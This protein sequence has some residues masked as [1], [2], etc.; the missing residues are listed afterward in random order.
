M[1]GR[2]AMKRLDG[3]HSAIFDEKVVIQFGSYDALVDSLSP[4][5]LEP[6]QAIAENNPR[7]MREAAR[8]VDRDVS[9]VHSD[10]KHLEVLGILELN[11]GGPGG[12]MQPV[13]RFDRNRDAYRLPARRRHRYH[14]GQCLNGQPQA[15][16]SQRSD[17]TLPPIS[18]PCVA[19]TVG[20][21]DS[22]AIIESYLNAPNEDVIDTALA[23]L[24]L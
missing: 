15:T 20:G 8:L 22:V 2:T 23:E 4:L 13:V 19:M 17:P 11:E 7:S 12:A 1:R 16:T 24:E 3:D 14:T 18:V 5:R 6:I 21:W 10:L 9:D